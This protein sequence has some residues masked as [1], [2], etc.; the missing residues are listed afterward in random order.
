MFWDIKRQEVRGAVIPRA[1]GSRPICVILT[2]S[3]FRGL[4]AVPWNGRNLAAEDPFMVILMMRK[5]E[6]MALWV[7]G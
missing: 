3:Y 6:R 1:L 2:S 5:R 4:E 7:H